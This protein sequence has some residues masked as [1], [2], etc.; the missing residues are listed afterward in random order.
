MQQK[1]GTPTSDSSPAEDT[2]ACSR[3]NVLAFVRFL[4][5]ARDEASINIHDAYCE[6]R[7]NECITHLS[8]KH[9]IETSDLF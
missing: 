4:F 6:A 2:D 3:Q 1:M 8:D 7:I 9:K 5:W